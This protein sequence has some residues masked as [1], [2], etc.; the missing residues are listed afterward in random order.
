MSTLAPGKVEYAKL[1]INYKSA[2]DLGLCL[3][4]SEKFNA[5]NIGKVNGTYHN[6]RD[7]G[8]VEVIC[9]PK[10]G[11]EVREFFKSTYDGY[12]IK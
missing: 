6:G 9:R 5:L 12:L 1:K 11:K 3:E 10:Q 2:T 8:Y 7:R 4:H